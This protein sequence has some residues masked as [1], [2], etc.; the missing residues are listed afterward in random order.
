MLS[1]A[2]TNK[3]SIKWGKD[4]IGF[5][6]AKRSKTSSSET[7]NIFSKTRFSVLLMKQKMETNSISVFKKDSLNVNKSVSNL[8]NDVDEVITSIYKGAYFCTKDGKCEKVKGGKIKFT[9]SKLY[10][11]EPVNLSKIYSERHLKFCTIIKQNDGRYKLVLPNGNVNY[12]TYKSGKLVNM[13]STRYGT[14][15]QFVAS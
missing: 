15:L 2:Q 7:I 1:N 5:L 8:N 11:Y 3:F 4:S 9:V 14:K 13:T 10:F 6:T 12:Y